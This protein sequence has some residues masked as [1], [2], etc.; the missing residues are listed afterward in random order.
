MIRTL[1]LHLIRPTEIPVELLTEIFLASLPPDGSSRPASKDGPLAISHVCSSWR[2]V[3]QSI[4]E[5]WCNL[6]L[7]TRASP[8][9]V[10]FPMV[11]GQWF[12]RAGKCPLSISIILINNLDENAVKFNELIKYIVTFAYRFRSI[13]LTLGQH[14]D[15]NTIIV[16]P[17]RDF[18]LLTFLNIHAQRNVGEPLSIFQSAPILRQTRLNLLPD[19]PNQISLPWFQ[20][21]HVDMLERLLPTYKFRTILCVLPSITHGAFF[22]EGFESHLSTGGS[23]GPIVVPTL[24]HLTVKIFGGDTSIFLHHINAPSLQSLHISGCKPNLPELHSQH[25]I[26]QLPHVVEAVFSQLIVSQGD[27]FIRIL[28]NC[29]ALRALTPNLNSDRLNTTNNVVLGSLQGGR[30]LMPHLERLTMYVPLSYSSPTD[31]IAETIISRWQITA[32]KSVELLFV[33][34]CEGM[35]EIR[36][37]LEQCIGAGLNVVLR[38]ATTPSPALVTWGA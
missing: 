22:V 23:S 18:E 26:H 4:P 27:E 36:R 16:K 17:Y 13:S 19:A 3:A 6:A 14:I 9:K 5:L 30:L 7:M 25:V 8:P 34:H 15:L 20:L 32:L 11:A 33:N 21:T 2:Q 28:A 1:S 12:D 31:R 38:E 24:T 37:Q 35:G 10:P 29:T